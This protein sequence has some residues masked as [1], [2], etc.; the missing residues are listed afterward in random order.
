MM[1][2][3]F[4]GDRVSAAMTMVRR[5]FF[6]Y[7][8]LLKISF[9]D[10]FAYVPDVMGGTVLLGFR[11]WIYFQLYS[12]TFAVNGLTDVDG[13]TVTIAFGRFV[14]CSWHY[15]PAE[16]N[17]ATD[18]GRGERGRDRHVIIKTIFIYAVPVCSNDGTGFWLGIDT[19]SHGDSS[20]C[21]ACRVTAAFVGGMCARGGIAWSW[22]TLNFL[23]KRP[24]GSVHCGRGQ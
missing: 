24:L 1:A 5:Q 19:G 10:L 20:G 11:L 9:L 8:S 22:I 13:T 2:V 18:R 23:C 16:F 21:N 3:P 17:L 12:V 14:L 15:S 4:T 6:L 7:G